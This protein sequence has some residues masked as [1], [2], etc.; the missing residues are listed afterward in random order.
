MKRK[1]LCE[2]W[3]KR[4]ATP[5]RAV[6]TNRFAKMHRISQRYAEMPKAS[7]ICQSPNHVFY[8][9]ERQYFNSTPPPPCLYPTQIQGKEEYVR[10]TFRE[11]TGSV[12]HRWNTKPHS[13]RILSISMSPVLSHWWKLMDITDQQ[14]QQ[15]QKQQQQQVLGRLPWETLSWCWKCALCSEVSLLLNGM[16]PLQASDAVNIHPPLIW[17]MN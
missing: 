12:M 13:N 1:I 7:V 6:R 17:V 8:V 5:K 3:F 10:N 11:A 14:Q 15:Q 16:H 4:T 9:M 2:W